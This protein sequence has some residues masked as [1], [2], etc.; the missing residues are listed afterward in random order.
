MP[1]QKERKPTF[2]VAPVI[3]RA[4]RGIVSTVMRTKFEG[5]LGLT[6]FTVRRLPQRPVHV[7]SS[8]EVASVVIGVPL[9]RLNDE[10][11]R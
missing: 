3:D 1:N 7:S 5:P 4:A 10:R 11:T 8:D 6:G 2:E 9:K